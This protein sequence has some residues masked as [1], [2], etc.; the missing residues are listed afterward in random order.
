MKSGL[1]WAVSDGRA[2]AGGGAPCFLHGLAGDEFAVIG[3]GARTKIGR[4]EEEKREVR[5]SFLKLFRSL[6]LSL[7][8]VS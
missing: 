6:V 2:G 5:A 3:E 1:P 8:R 7:C 4:K